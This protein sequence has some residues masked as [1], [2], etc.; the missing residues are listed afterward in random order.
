[1]LAMGTSDVS[2]LRERRESKCQLLGRSYV[3]T[4]YWGNPYPCIRKRSK[5][6]QLERGCKLCGF[7]C[8][9]VSSWGEQGDLG[10]DTGLNEP[11]YWSN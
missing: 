4:N 9:G 6:Q 1:M 5:H 8:L 2:Q 3:W 11:K 10:P 7:T